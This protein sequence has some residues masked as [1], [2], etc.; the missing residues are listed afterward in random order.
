ML[1]VKKMTMAEICPKCGLPTDICVCIAIRK[2]QQRIKVYVDRRKWRRYATIIEGLDDRELNV[3]ELAKQL[4]SVCACGGA[5]KSNQ[6]ILQGD[7]RNK[8]R[9]FLVRYGFPVENIEVI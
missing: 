3:R 6:I 4:K 1:E 9:D 7:H 8:T 2:E 5:V